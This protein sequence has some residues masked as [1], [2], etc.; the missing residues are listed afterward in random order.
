MA[1][2]TAFERAYFERVRRQNEQLDEPA[3]PA[4]LAEMFDRLEA[5]RRLHGTLANPGVA[6]GGDGD[7]ASHLAYLDRIHRIGSGGA[8][9]T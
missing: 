7:L 8:D 6:D 4:S 3:V 2:A 1:R 5:M 9:R